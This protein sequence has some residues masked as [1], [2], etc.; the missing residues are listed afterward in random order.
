MLLPK[1]QPRFES[2]SQCWAT[3]QALFDRLDAEFHFEWDLAAAVETAKCAKFYT[4]ADDAL[5]HDWRGVCWLN[6]PFN[7]KTARLKR[8]IEKA[9]ASAL[10]GATVVVL[11]PAHTN[12]VWWRDHVMKA[13]EIRFICG[14]PKFGNATCGLIQSLAIVVFKPNCGSTLISSYQA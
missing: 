2:R 6:P 12:T 1:R 9:Y 14:R 13:S 11:T 3:P 8:W 4:E 10:N 5:Q 7:S